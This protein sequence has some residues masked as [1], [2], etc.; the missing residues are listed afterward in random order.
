MK[1]NNTDVVKKICTMVA[2]NN[3]AKVAAIRAGSNV[4]DFWRI[5]HHF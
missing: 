3:N 5:Q 2:H 1:S 4:E